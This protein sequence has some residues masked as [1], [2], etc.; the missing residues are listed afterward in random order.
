MEQAGARL[1]K[2]GR[3]TRRLLNNLISGVALVSLFVG[4]AL[5]FRSIQNVQGWISVFALLGIGIYWILLGLSNLEIHE[6][7]ILDLSGLLTWDNVE[8]YGW[9]GQKGMTLVLK[10]KPRHPFFRYFPYL[11]GFFSEAFYL[12]WASSLQIPISPGQKNLVESAIQVRGAPS[13]KEP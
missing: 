12:F 6:N 1:V 3:L 11:Q 5:V 9:V 7:G 10:L 13:T 2:L 4:T 8:S